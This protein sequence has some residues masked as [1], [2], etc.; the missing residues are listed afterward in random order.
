MLNEPRIC[1]DC[2]S[3]VK[4]E[5][6]EARACLREAIAHINTWATEENMPHADQLRKW[7]C[8]ANDNAHSSRVSAAKEG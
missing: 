4:T 2:H 3:R 7:V 5:R 6:D 1:E 8:I